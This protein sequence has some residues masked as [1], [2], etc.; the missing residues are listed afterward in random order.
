[1]PPVPFSN[2]R[3]LFVWSAVRCSRR[4]RGDRR[5]PP[6]KSVPQVVAAMSVQRD[7]TSLLST[8][9]R[10]EVLA[11]GSADQR[12][13]NAERLIASLRQ[14]V[15]GRTATFSSP[16]GECP[17]IYVDNTASGRPLACIEEYIN[18]VV[19]PTYGNTHTTSS[20]CGY[21]ST[22][23]REEARQ[24]I[25]NATNCTDKDHLIFSGEPLLFEA[26]SA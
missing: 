9:S 19:L 3:Q 13:A 20:I 26:C 2:Q 15:V 10:K 23:F 16:F 17:I 1:M 24:I 11:G 8:E 6:A 22:M 21:Q 18:E 4:L 12:T 5:E 25:K 14:S 7:F